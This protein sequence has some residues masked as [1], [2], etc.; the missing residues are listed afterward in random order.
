MGYVKN[1]GHVWFNPD[2]LANILSMAKMRKVCRITMDTSVEPAMSVHRRDGSIMKFNKYKSGL[3]YFDTAAPKTP[4]STSF[5]VNAY[6]FLNTVEQNKQAYIRRKIEGADRARELYEKI[7][8]PSKKG[9]TDILQNNLIRNCPVTPDDAKRALQIYGPGV[10]TLQ[11]KTVKKQNSGIPNYQAVQIPAPIITQYNNACLFVDI[12]WVNNSPY[13]HTISEWVKF[14]TVAAIN[15]ITQR[16]LH[17]ETQ[18]VIK[19]YE[20][21]VFTVTRA[22]GDQEF[23]CLANDLL[24]TPLNIADT[25]D[26]V[27]QVERSIRTIKER[28]RCL[29]QGLPFKRIPKAMMRAAI[30]NANKALNQFPAKNGVS[31]TLSP[32]TIMTGRPT[33]DYNDMKIEFGTYAQVFKDNNPTS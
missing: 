19:L 1:F 25:D 13:L 14:R 2:S 27:A 8:Q 30:K 3:Y 10:A 23:S 20:T 12:F 26:H 24:P 15:N 33:P 6:L 16:T 32:L 17:M 21:R 5:N 18:A 7:G 9:F 11:G 22:K 4:N 28:V 29:V 31:D